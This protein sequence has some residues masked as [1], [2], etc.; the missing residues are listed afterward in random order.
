[1]NDMSAL[2]AALQVLNAIPSDEVPLL[3]TAKNFG[4]EDFHYS[5]KLMI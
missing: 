3:D 5:S 2:G 1:M 4:E